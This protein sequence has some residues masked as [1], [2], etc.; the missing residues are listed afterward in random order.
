MPFEHLYSQCHTGQFLI[1]F[2][3]SL[4]PTLNH[5]FKFGTEN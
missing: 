1:A 3:D 2:L 5:N 4:L